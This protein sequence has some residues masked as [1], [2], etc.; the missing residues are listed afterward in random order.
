MDEMNSIRMHG[1]VLMKDVEEEDDGRGCA[2]ALLFNRSGRVYVI[3]PR[4]I[5]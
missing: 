1:W 4:L 2:S 5:T 3:D